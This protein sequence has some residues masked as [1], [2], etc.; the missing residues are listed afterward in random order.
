MILNR[1]YYNSNSGKKYG[2]VKRKQIHIRATQTKP[3]MD[4]RPSRN[5]MKK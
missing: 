3:D 4:R 2:K 5:A 1:I